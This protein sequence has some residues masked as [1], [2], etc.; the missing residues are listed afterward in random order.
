MKSE[1]SVTY[2]YQNYS[3]RYVFGL[4]V[5]NKSIGHT[6]CNGNIVLAKYDFKVKWTVH[7]KMK[8]GH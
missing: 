8:F 3:M 1:S 6:S 7:P 5:D 4:R 2:V